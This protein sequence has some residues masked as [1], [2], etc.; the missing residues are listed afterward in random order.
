MTVHQHTFDAIGCT[1]S[2]LTTDPNTLA[3]AAEL[4]EA[5]VAELDLAA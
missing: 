5:T 3:R 2:V 4:A 1:H